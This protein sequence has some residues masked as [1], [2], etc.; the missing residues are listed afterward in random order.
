MIIKKSTSLL[1]KALIYAFVTYK[2]TYFILLWLLIEKIYR[3]SKS[4]S[5]LL[6][7][8]LSFFSHGYEI[9]QWKI[10]RPSFGRNPNKS[11]KSFPPCY[12]RLQLL[13][14]EISI[15]SK[16]RNLSPFLLRGEEENLKDNHTALLMVKECHI[17]KPQVWELSRLCPE[18]SLNLYVHEFC[19]CTENRRVYP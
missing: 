1:I 7:R 12:S 9:L 2:L 13:C 16:S 5:S 4:M 15:S 17:E 8:L 19:F 14:I 3:L 18:T 6:Q 10:L 11:L